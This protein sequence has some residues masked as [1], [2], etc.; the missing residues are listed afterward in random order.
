MEE[1]LVFDFEAPEGRLE[2]W[3]GVSGNK[4]E[5]SKRIEEAKRAIDVQ[6]V[7]GGI[8]EHFDDPNA[9][10]R[11]S[12]LDSICRPTGALHGPPAGKL[13]PLAG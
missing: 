4:K 12:G 2:E 9:A 10:P 5:L 3:D 6:L 13:P 7:E 11:E 8:F 1:E